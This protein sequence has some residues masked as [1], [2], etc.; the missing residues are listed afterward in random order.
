MTQLM[1]NQAGYRLVTDLP[2]EMRP[3]RDR[4]IAWENV[5][6]ATG[7]YHL[8][9]DGVYLYYPDAKSAG[10]DHPVGQAQFGLGCISSFRTE[11]DPARRAV[12][13]TRA[14]AQADRLIAKHTEAREAWWFPYGFDFTHTVHTGV[15]YKAP[16]YSG[17]AQGEVLSLLVQLS[18]L[19]GVC[20]EDRARY[21]AA[22]DAAFASLQVADD[23][24]PWAVNVDGAGYVW[25][26]EYPGSQPGTGDYTYNGMIF[27]MLG[28]WDYYVATGSQ[29]AAALYDGCATTIARYFPLLRNTKWASFYCQTHRIPAPAYHQHHINLLRQLNWQTGSPDFADHTDRLV[30]D[31]PANA[32]GTVQFAAGT[33]TLYRYDT[34]ADGSWVESRADKILETKS[35]TFSRATQAPASMR[36]RI[37]N[38]G[39]YYRISAGAYTGWW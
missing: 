21:L 27:A 38:R 25:L 22:A 7:T 34:A 33:H 5:S 10:L 31:Y 37:Q 28:L 19:D 14:R 2:E 11:T 39:I 18:Q 15:S 29:D 16:W 4:P 1:F 26:Q 12:F 23:G 32:A 17:M 24:Y 3:W 13:L 9:T 6:P 8:N 20:G 36:R 30:D 35:V